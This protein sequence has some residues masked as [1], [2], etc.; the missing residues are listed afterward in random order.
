MRIKEKYVKYIFIYHSHNLI[1]VYLGQVL[2][3]AMFLH[4]SAAVIEEYLKKDLR[5]DTNV[6]QNLAM[7]DTNQKG[8][9]KCAGI[10]ALDEFCFGFSLDQPNSKCSTLQCTRPDEQQKSFSD[11]LYAR[12][13]TNL[14]DPSLLARGI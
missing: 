2:V 3:V 10:C 6:S 13:D 12:I 7:V 1:I 14:E 8:M 4:H 9:V 11:N 5:K